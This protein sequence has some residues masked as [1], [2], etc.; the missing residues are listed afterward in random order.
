MVTT[1]IALVIGGTCTFLLFG[2]PILWI[3][4]KY[5]A[6]Q[7]RKML[8]MKQQQLLDAQIRYYSSAPVQYQHSSPPSVVY[9]EKETIREIVRRPCPYCG[10]LV[11]N[12][13]TFCPSCGARI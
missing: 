3:W 2:I 12:T 4:I 11:E 1:D 8:D 9:R 5:R 6:R 13:A 10:T 7:R